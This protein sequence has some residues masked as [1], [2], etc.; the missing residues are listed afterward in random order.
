MQGGFCCFRAVVR[1][2]CQLIDQDAVR[3]GFPEGAAQDGDI[4][5]ALRRF[6]CHGEALIPALP[7]PVHALRRL[8]GEG[9]AA[10]VR[11][12]EYHLQSAVTQR[13]QKRGFP[14]TKPFL[15]CCR[16]VRHSKQSVPFCHA[17]ALQHGGRIRLCEALLHLRIQQ[18]AGGGKPLLQ[19][20]LLHRLLCPAAVQA[21]QL[22]MPDEDA[23]AL[24]G[25]VMPDRLGGCGSLRIKALVLAECQTIERQ[26]VLAGD[27]ERLGVDAFTD[28]F[29]PAA[30]QQ[31]GQ[32]EQKQGVF[33][34]GD[35]S[36]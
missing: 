27:A 32:E 36:G 8:C 16:T 24:C 18:L 9:G 7:E 23:P 2:D 33:V 1:K 6:H 19:Q 34:H 22:R 26:C 15:Q 4:L 14:G 28:M 3:G 11:V 5:H 20:K 12:Q 30:R 10:A 25:F 21:E 13:G 31:K 29:R 17:D 35:T